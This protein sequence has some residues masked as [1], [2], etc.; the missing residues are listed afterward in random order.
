MAGSKTIY[1][2]PALLSRLR[3][4]N[5][6]KNVQ[7]ELAK[8]RELNKGK[9]RAFVR[10]WVRILSSTDQELKTNKIEFQQLT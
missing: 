10:T 9:P 3:R 5:S 7:E 6:F 4:A 1:E 8:V 2:P